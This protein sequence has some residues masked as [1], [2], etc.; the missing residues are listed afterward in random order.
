[1]SRLQRG[2]IYKINTFETS[3]Q[4]YY[5]TLRDVSTQRK[6]RKSYFR[7]PNDMNPRDVADIFSDV[8]Q[9]LDHWKTNKAYSV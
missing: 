8:L 6:L 9:S 7:D 5:Q 2:V 1:M 4:D 3:D